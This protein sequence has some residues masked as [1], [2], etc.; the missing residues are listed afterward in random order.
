MGTFLRVVWLPATVVALV[1]GW[2]W[3]D[4]AIGWR[5]AYLPEVGLP[6]VVA[7]ALLSLWCAAVFLFVGKGSP[8]PF[9]RKTKYLVTA[10]PYGVVRN[11]MMWGIGSLL[12]GLA[13][14]LGSV[15]LWF[16][17]AGFVLF[18]SWFV[19]HYEEPDMER[20]F[21]QAY[22][23]YCRQTPRWWPLGHRPK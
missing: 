2:L 9:V 20:R 7:G 4:A 5:G 11:P 1:L 13:L 18:V 21:G 12:I 15:G 23:E 19:P 3:L 17:F 8:H 22:R 10:G 16:G 14:T 6:M